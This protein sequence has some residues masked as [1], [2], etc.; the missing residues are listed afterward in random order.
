MSDML[1]VTS[2]LL[3]NWHYINEKIIPFHKNINFFTGHS[4]SGK[5]TVIDALQVLLYADTDGRGFFNKAAKDDSN[6]TLIEYLR[7]M[8]NVSESG[9]STYLRNQN[10]SSTIAL[11]LY[12]T[13]TKEY[14]VIGVTFD[15][16]TASNDVDRMFFWHKGKRLENGYRY[17]KNTMTCNQL[18]EYLKRSFSVENWWISRTNEKF[19]QRLYDTYLGGLDD[20]KF[21]MLFKKAISFRMDTRL[22]DFVKEFIC[23]EKDI[24]IEDMQES[25]I[26]YVRLKR[27]LEDTKEEIEHLMEIH[28]KYEVYAQSMNAL[29]QYEYN[30]QQLQIDWLSERIATNQHKQ[31]AYGEDIDQL[32]EAVQK[33][34]TRQKEI[35]K[36]QVEIKTAIGNSGYEHLISEQASK[37]ELLG[38]MKRSKQRLDETLDGLF[39]LV[40]EECLKEFD[41]V[42]EED[43]LKNL[44]AI[45]QYPEEASFIGA[46]KERLTKV[47]SQLLTTKDHIQKKYNIYNDQL[48]QLKQEYA[49]LKDGKKAYPLEV[50]EAKEFIEDGLRTITG[51][52]VEVE[53]LAD[54]IE[55]KNESWQNAVEGYLSNQKLALLV[56]PEYCKEALGLYQDLDPVKYHKVTVIDTGK[57][58]EHGKTP[59]KGALSEEIIT[60]FD[61]VKAYTDFVLG[62]VIKCNS[63]EELRETKCGITRDCVLYQGYRIQH[64]APKHY[65]KFAYIGSGSMEKRMKTLEESMVSVTTELHPVSE[66]LKQVSNLLMVDFLEKETEEY[67]E[68]CKDSRRLLIL[69]EEL[70]R[71]ALQI[72]ELKS[73]NVEKWRKEEAELEAEAITCQQNL[74]KA[75]SSKET[76]E[77]ELGRLK[78]EYLSLNEEKE[79]A[80]AQLVFDADRAAKYRAYRAGKETY[81]LQRINEEL[82]NFI[83]VETAKQEKAFEALIARREKYKAAYSYRGFSVTSR[84][85]AAYE[86]LLEKLSSEKLAEFTKL[87]AEQAKKAILHFKTDFV[88]KVRDAIKEAIQQ[89]DDLNRILKQT[90]FGKEKYRFVIEK[91]KGEDGKFYAMFMDENLEINPSNLS[92]HMDNQM[93][94]FTA[95]HEDKY[96]D[97]INELIDIF[98]PP[99]NSNQEQLEEARRN[100]EKYADYRTYLSFDM[101][102]IIEGMAPMRLSKMLTKNS[103]GEG[104]NPLYVALLASFA[105]VYRIS[106]RGNVRRRLTPRLV[107]LDEAFSKMDGEKVASCLELIRK[108]GFQAI[109]SATN[110]KIQNY[111][112]SVDKTFVFANPNKSYISIQEFERQDFSELLAIEE[113]Q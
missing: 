111:V 33:Y 66:K 14:Q 23:V 6:R 30:Q 71:L 107:V 67:V 87:A 3:N 37:G 40:N 68:L 77:L 74:N 36:K 2:L 57:V 47:K 104:Q 11:E 81:R 12:N 59:L 9:E 35:Q 91:N 39:G 44:Q 76:K 73:Q 29:G 27:K 99:E 113:N 15:V 62:N 92:D 45:R 58:M 54:L 49:T 86:E 13:E 19:R 41:L 93:D 106:L 1:R 78:Q 31:Q 8:N 18:K 63:I 89:K 7:G 88:Y 65:T 43:L 97:Q 100:I 94:L 25:V 20:R 108:L 48:A 80:Q 4:G 112:E 98:M 32:V 38:R 70:S 102:Q 75:S 82:T 79:K 46:V 56:P 84:D 103:G 24:H 110:D 96:N 34:S 83:K 69:Q 85:N 101:E 50:V 95:S 17:E 72:E 90:D 10:F 64:I 16:E 60:K 21:P 53:I 5:S 51:Q 26:Q 55:I 52:P 22:E 28:D 42:I 61:Y 105:E 109:I